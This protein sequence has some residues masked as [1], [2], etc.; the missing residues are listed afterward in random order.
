MEDPAPR[1]DTKVLRTTVYQ[2][3]IFFVTEQQDLNDIRDPRFYAHLKS[4]PS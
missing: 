4:S 2:L 1:F 3:S